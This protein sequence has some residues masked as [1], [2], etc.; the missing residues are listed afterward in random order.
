LD[1]PGDKS[2]IQKEI[3][4]NWYALENFLN[5]RN[6]NKKSPY[7]L[8]DFCAERGEVRTVFIID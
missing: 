1:L 3:Q 7:Y 8:E 5:Q 6:Y 2:R 4:T